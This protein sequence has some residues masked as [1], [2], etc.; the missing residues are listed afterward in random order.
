MGDGG[1]QFGWRRRSVPP[2]GPDAF[3]ESAMF[4]SL[5]PEVIGTVG[6]PSSS[7]T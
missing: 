7:P 2:S 5:D 1:D 6:W 3:V 4:P